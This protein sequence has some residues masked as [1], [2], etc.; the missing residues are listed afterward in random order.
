[1]VQELLTRGAARVYSTGRSP[2]PQAEGEVIPLLLDVTDADAV[3]EAAEKLD[4]VSIVVNNAGILLAGGV[5]DGPIG[6]IRT[7]L[8][9]NLF[10]VLNV[11][12]AFAPVLAR[13]RPGAVVN[14]LSAASW[15]ASGRSYDL[16]KAAAWS[17]TNSLRLQLLDQGTTVTALHVGPMDTPAIAAL[18]VPKSDPR[19]I[20]RQTVDAVIAGQFEVLADQRSRDI[21][22][23]LCRDLTEI[24]PQ[25]VR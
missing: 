15:A 25:L 10:G 13:N 17:A 18:E 19:D 8:E 4:D 5:L 21:K 3:A 24:Y 12:R 6:D 14:V 1:M 7:E 11:S 20:A 2:Q 16:T 23:R 22:A 9:T